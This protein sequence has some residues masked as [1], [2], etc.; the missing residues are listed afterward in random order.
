MAEQL[1]LRLYFLHPKYQWK[2]S[3]AC[4]P[5]YSTYIFPYESDLQ[6][7]QDVSVL[8]IS[9]R[10]KWQFTLIRKKNLTPRAGIIQQCLNKLEDG[11]DRNKKKLSKDKWEVV[12]SSTEMPSLAGQ[13]SADSTKTSLFIPQNLTKL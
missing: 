11:T 5:L 13:K 1:W 12:Q 10:N 2:H 8:K 4:E 6:Q 9:V 3:G 7:E